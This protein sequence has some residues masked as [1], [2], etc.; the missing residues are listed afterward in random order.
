MNFFTEEL[1]SENRKFGTGWLSG[2]LGLVLA[3]VGLAIVLCFW[4]PGILTV[5]NTRGFYGENVHLVRGLLHLVLISAFLLGLL[6]SVLRPRKIL[7]FTTIA[8][9]LAATL[10]GGSQATAKTQLTSD[11]YFGLDFFLLNLTFLGALFIPIERLFKKVDQPILR[12]EW[13]EDLLYFLVSTL[14]VQSLT[15]LSLAP[16]LATIAATGWANGLRETVASQ[17]LVLQFFEIMFLTDFVQYWF[18]RTFHK[19]PSLWNFH[20]VHHSAQA[21]DWIAGSRM[22]VVEVILLRSFT[23]LPM[24][25]MGFAEAPLYAYVF[26][27]YMI[28]VFIHA[29]IRIPFGFLQYIIATPRFHHWHHGVEEEAIDKNF[30]IHFPV[31]DMVFGTFHMPGDRWPDGY[32]IEGHPVPKG[33]FRQLLYPFQKKN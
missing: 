29:N 25:V 7:G 16:S 5:E 10:M 22:H 15:Y 3:L 12:Y 4:F 20:A 18:H 31:I 21:M 30:A 32:G 17:P 27:V 28:S 11:A 8:I 1:D 23:T 6:S 2:F 19:V 26:F 14:F 24:Y 33:Y 9:V 13:R